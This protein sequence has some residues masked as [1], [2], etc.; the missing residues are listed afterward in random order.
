M[1]LY[2]YSLNFT[3]YLHEL[4]VIENFMVKFIIDFNGDF[5]DDFD[6]DFISNCCE[7]H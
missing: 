5:N 6:E 1:Y 7:E 2:F 4:L 3:K